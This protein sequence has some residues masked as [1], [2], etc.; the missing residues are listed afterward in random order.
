MKRKRYQQYITFFSYKMLQRI[1]VIALLAM[2]FLA[3]VAHAAPV[4]GGHQ[5]LQESNVFM[6]R[7][8]SAGNSGGE[9]DESEKDEKE[10]EKDEDES[11]KARPGSLQGG[12]TQGGEKDENEKDEN[13]TGN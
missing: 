1:N 11:P 8:A 9:K 3:V 6:K 7:V 4:D 10:D 12:K 13:D 5:E 2:I